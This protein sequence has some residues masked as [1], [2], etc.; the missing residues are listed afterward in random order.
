MANGKSLTPLEI[1]KVLEQS[2]CK[3]CMLPGCLAF[4]AAVVGGQKNLDDCPHLSEEVKKTLSATLEKRSTAE[5]RQAEF[6]GKLL[7]EIKEIDLAAV[8][9]RIGGVYDN[10]TLSVRS[11]GK[12]FHVD[13]QGQ[14]RSECHIIPWVQAPLLAYICND[15][16]QAITGNWISF[17][18]LRG[19]ID[20]RGLFHSRCETPLRMLADKHPDLLADIVDLFMGEE[21]EGFEAD[22][23]LVLHPLPHIPILLCYQAPDGDLASELNIFFDACC[24][25]NL[26]IKSI[27]TLCAGLVKMFEQIALKHY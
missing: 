11:L 9:P 24:G 25:E 1:Y 15:S 6:M 14:V 26:H 16:H 7:E 2:N 5:P 19:G 22:I 17:R 4:A 20:W 12:E 18:E 23:A 21:V 8:A 27:Y 3:Q 13:G 10:G